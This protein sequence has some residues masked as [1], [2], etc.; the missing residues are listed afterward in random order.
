MLQFSE[1]CC[2]LSIPR[3]CSH[4]V[5]VV[6]LFFLIVLANTNNNIISNYVLYWMQE[7]TLVCR[8]FKG[9]VTDHIINE[10]ILEVND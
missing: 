8:V 2:L 7:Q 5:P 6:R 4:V 10:I 9:T 3:Q 1:C